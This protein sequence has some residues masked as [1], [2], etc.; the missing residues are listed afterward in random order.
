MIPSGGPDGLSTPS[1]RLLS[2][3]LAFLLVSLALGQLGDGLNIFQGIYLVGK[4]WNE[5][6]VGIALSLMGLTSLVIQPWAGDWVDKTTVDRRIFLAVASLATA[7]SASTVMLVRDGNRDHG[8]MYATKI[9]E[10]AVSSF[11]GPCLAALT[12]A[13]FG[14]RNFD[15]IM[16]S[17]IMWGHIGSV[18]AAVL[19]GWVSYVM[20][21]EIKLCFL[22][23]GA[24][25]LVAC[26]LVRFLPEGDPLMGRGFAGKTAMDENG[27]L[28]KLD[29]QDESDTEFQSSQTDGVEE[30]VAASY[31]EVF[32]DPRC[33]ILCFTGFF[34]Q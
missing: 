21:P 16:A 8:L 19:A 13:T 23:V 12:L 24:S 30:P 32:A 5:G 11:I 4:G 20:Y 2:P 33:V 18:V 31:S 3:K 29:S 34:F 28:E 15:S 22:V 25:A 17:N 1:R 7:L 26:F 9:M 6:S 27:E 10:G 14:P